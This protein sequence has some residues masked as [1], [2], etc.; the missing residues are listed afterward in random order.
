MIQCNHDK[1][2]NTV[3]EREVHTMKRTATFTKNEIAIQNNIKNTKDVKK[4]DLIIQVTNTLHPRCDRDYYNDIKDYI[5]VLISFGHKVTEK[6]NGGWVF[7]QGRQSV[8]ELYLCND[9]LIHIYVRDKT[10]VHEIEKRCKCFHTVNEKW[11]YE[12]RF[13]FTKDSFIEFILS[14]NLHF[15]TDTF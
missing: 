2:N 9:N 13:E 8:C 15:L 6:K 7:K 10:A 5:N 12:D 11:S 4:N 1:D 14:D 3:N